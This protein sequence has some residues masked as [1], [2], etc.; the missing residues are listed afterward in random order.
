MQG[1][2][3]KDIGD[4]VHTTETDGNTL[5]SVDLGAGQGFQDVVYLDGVTGV[6][7]HALH[8]AGSLIV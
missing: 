2:T 7:L 8:D 3:F 5:I 1:A 4:V 6:D